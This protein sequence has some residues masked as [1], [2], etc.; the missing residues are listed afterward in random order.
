M[1]LQ[2]EGGFCEGQKEE[3]T[4]SEDAEE[5]ENQGREHMRE[6]VIKDLHF[7]QWLGMKKMRV[8]E[9][10]SALYSKWTH[11]I[12]SRQMIGDPTSRYTNS[13]GSLLPHYTFPT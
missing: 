4:F 13:Q 3:E 1:S 10:L 11:G 5:I 12:K 7:R 8:T 6:K 2:V 9:R